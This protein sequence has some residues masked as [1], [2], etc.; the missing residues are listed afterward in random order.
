MEAFFNSVIA[1]MEVVVFYLKGLFEI[2]EGTSEFFSATENTGEVVISDS[3]VAVSLLSKHLS[4]AEE[5]QSHIEV[6][7]TNR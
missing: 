1:E 4:L 6:F 5:L 2:G 3:A 7:Y